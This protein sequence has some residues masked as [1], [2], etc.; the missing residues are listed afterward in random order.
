MYGSC[1]LKMPEKDIFV[2]NQDVQ[3]FTRKTDV[4]WTA[5]RCRMLFGLWLPEP[6]E[7]RTQSRYRELMYNGCGKTHI[8]RNVRAGSCA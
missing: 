4:K 2:I 3:I 7:S 5:L 6:R 8:S 1:R